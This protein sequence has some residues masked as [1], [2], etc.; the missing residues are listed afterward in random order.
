MSPRLCEDII[1]IF[2]FKYFFPVLLGFLRVI[3]NLL[4]SMEYLFCMT[5]VLK[6]TYSQEHI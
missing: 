6:E 4:Y 5:I 1:S 3:V 2:C